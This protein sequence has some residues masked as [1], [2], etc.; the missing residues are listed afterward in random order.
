[1]SGRRTDAYDPDHPTDF[2]DARVITLAKPLTKAEAIRTGKRTIEKK[3]GAG[4]NSHVVSS[5]GVRATTVEAEDYR[6][7]VADHALKDAIQKARLAKGLTQK[8]LAMACS[9]PA[10]VVQSYENGTAVIIQSELDKMSSALGVHLKK[11]KVVK[12]PTDG[13]KK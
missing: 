10:S 4:G 11:P 2:Q 6:P 13:V 9:M 1:M 3:F 12:P 8:S 7:P 5:T